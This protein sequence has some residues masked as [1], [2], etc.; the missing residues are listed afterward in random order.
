MSWL[1]IFDNFLDKTLSPPEYKGPPKP[2]G[3]LETTYNKI[4]DAVCT[5]QGIG[6]ICQLK[7]NTSVFSLFKGSQMVKPLPLSLPP[8]HTYLLSKPYSLARS[9]LSPSSI[10]DG[11]YSSQWENFVSVRHTFLRCL[12]L[13][14][15][16]R[17]LYETCFV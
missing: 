7:S 3:I 11:G 8:C 2:C 5:E 14:N 15:C 6:Y 17:D 4:D 1:N 12:P 13:G 16:W 10:E 9:F